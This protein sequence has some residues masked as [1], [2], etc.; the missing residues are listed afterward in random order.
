MLDIY[1][2]LAKKTLDANS[3]DLDLKASNGWFE[4]LKKISEIH[5]VLRH[6]MAA[7]SSRKEAEKFKKEL[8]YLNKA[9]GFVPQQVF[10]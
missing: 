5:S 10:N 9:E 1:V 3:K 8:S 6:G 7:S 4:K 2:D